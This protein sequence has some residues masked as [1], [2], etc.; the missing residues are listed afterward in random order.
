[1]TN[2][3]AFWLLLAVAFAPSVLAQDSYAPPSESAGGWRRCKTPEE[4]RSLGGMDPEKLGI[5]RESQLAL[6]AGPWQIVP[7]R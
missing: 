3:L 4:V 5:L 1:M 7:P 6:F 2:K